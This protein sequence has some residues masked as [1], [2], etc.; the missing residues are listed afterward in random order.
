DLYFQQ[1]SDIATG[2]KNATA[3]GALATE[4]YQFHPKFAVYDRLE[5]FRDPQGF[6]SAIYTNNSGRQI[7]YESYGGTIGV[8]YKP[9]TN[10]YIRVEYR[11]LQMASHEDIFYTDHQNVAYR[12]DLMVNMG[13]FFD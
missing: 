2:T 7:G 4:K 3:Y 5:L 13:V 12:N 10:S 6:L 11:R 1:N 9:S 8:E